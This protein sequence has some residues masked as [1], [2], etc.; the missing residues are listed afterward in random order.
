MA[1]TAA[2]ML[3]KKLPPKQFA[4]HCLTAIC[5]ISALS[6]LE[7]LLPDVAMAFRFL[8]QILVN[9]DLSSS[10]YTVESARDLD[11]LGFTRAKVLATEPA[12]AGL[13]IAALTF[14][15]LWS[16]RP[17][18]VGWSVWAIAMLALNLTVRSPILA[19]VMLAAPSLFL[20]SNLKRLSVQT[21][22]AAIVVGPLI[23]YSAIAFLFSQFSGKIE[24]VFQG[25]G[26]AIMRFVVPLDFTYSYLIQHPF[27]GEGHVGNY[28]RLAPDIEAAYAQWGMF[29]INDSVASSSISNAIAVH[30][31]NFGLLLGVIAAGLLIRFCWLVA[32]SHKM[33]IL[34]QMLVLW[35]Y[36]G[37][38]VSA[39]LWV[40]SAAVLAAA[41][42]FDSA[43][44]LTKN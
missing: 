13:S 36:Q 26:S 25:E 4:A 7:R 27:V 8:S 18:L 19:L 31:I 14:C 17:R 38:Y 12:H 44:R 6:V 22:A 35:V 34:F 23:A 16:V 28:E 33:V 3:I 10:L 42:M 11:L 24:A 2:Y 40:L 1:A 32:P 9:G 15:W 21:L 5:V 37:G 39:R 29:Y 43:Q 20:A 41:N 30:F